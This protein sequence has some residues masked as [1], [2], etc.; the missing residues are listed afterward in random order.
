MQTVQQYKLLNQSSAA[1]A[2]YD[3]LK[4]VGA[5][6]CQPLTIEQCGNDE[7]PG[8]TPFANGWVMVDDE[9]GETCGM[10]QNRE[11]VAKICFGSRAFWVATAEIYVQGITINL[12]NK[13][14]NS[15]VDHAGW[16]LLPYGPT[17]S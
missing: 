6:D 5:R 4:L 9:M 16:S 17:E 12:H 11:L 10:Y 8:Y 3:I 14:E 13:G 15:G 1:H 2:L 7:I